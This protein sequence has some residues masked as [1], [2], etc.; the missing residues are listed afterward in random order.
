MTSFGDANIKATHETL[1][2]KTSKPK[3]DVTAHKGLKIQ[4]DNRS[5]R[6]SQTA[7]AGAYCL[8]LLCIG[9]VNKSTNR[10]NQMT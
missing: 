10:P 1:N 9:R 6:P 7:A 2:W 8:H 5:H 3:K 4:E